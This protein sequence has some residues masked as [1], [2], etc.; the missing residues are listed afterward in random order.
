MRIQL[1]FL[2]GLTLLL[3]CGTSEQSSKKDLPDS[4]GGS[5]K[6]LVVVGEDLWSGSIG[7][8]LK[9]VFASTYPGLIGSEAYL[10]TN[11]VIPQK[12]NDLYKT[13][14]IVIVP[15]VLDQPNH[16]Q[17]VLSQDAIDRVKE[18]SIFV[19]EKSN[20]WA[21]NQSV[22]FLVA[23]TIVD[24]KT[25][26]KKNKKVLLEL[27]DNKLVEGLL[28]E[29]KIKNRSLDLEEL[30]LTKDLEIVIPEK[31][32]L[33]KDTTD[34]LWLRSYRKDADLNIVISSR[35]YESQEQFSDINLVEFRDSVCELIFVDPV[36]TA[37]YMITETYLDP[38][39][40]SLETLNGYSKKMNG[41]WRINNFRLG[42][43]SF[44]S[45][46]FLNPEKTRQYYI[47][48]FVFAP[49]KEKIQYLRKLDATLK[50]ITFF[51]RKH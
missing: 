49:Q 14:R 19:L 17:N 22:F 5:K 48:G 15:I 39:I 43:G 16:F 37:S 2:F 25:Q 21:N 28:V 10:S 23:P 33:A 13:Q 50:S 31:Y 8:S 40:A 46:S 29:M 35:V 18:G 36:D 41:L 27:I 24:F 38:V 51:K 9:K 45:Y 11:N 7:D 1:I 4:I 6:V 20:V 44:I 42:G 26:L 32:L 30:V 47:E 3:S 12:F 34:F